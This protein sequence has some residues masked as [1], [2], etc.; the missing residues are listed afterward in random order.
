MVDLFAGVVRLMK[1]DRAQHVR[2]IAKLDAALAALGK[3]VG[4]RHAMSAA[5]RKRI[6][7]AQKARWAKAKKQKAQK[8]P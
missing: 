2:E 3:T 6:S 7:L 4:P 1:R 5:A 8:S